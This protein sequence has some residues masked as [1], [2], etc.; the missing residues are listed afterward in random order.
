MDFD[1]R[2]LVD[3]DG[4]VIVEI[5]LLHAALRHRDVAEQG[6]GHPEDQPALH[7]RDHAVGI[8]D[9]AALDRAHEAVDADVARL[10]HLHHGHVP[11]E[12][13]DRVLVRHHD[14]HTCPARNTK[15]S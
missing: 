15:L 8:D 12:L 6:G 1:A 9:Y 11:Q 3:P 2:R 5:A 10:V 14:P 13:D 4:A 7:L